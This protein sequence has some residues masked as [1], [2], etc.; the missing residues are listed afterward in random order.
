MHYEMDYKKKDY[1]SLPQEECCDLLSTMKEK[2]NLKQA[3]DQIKILAAYKVPADSGSN[4]SPRVPQNK[5]ATTGVLLV[6]KKHGNKIPSIKVFS[7]NA[8]CAR[9]LKFQI[10]NINRIAQEF[11]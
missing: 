3:A 1:F 7:A 2:Y 4:A 6:R 10:A 8:L 9:I 5:K 11:I